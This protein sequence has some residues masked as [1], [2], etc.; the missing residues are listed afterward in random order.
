MGDLARRLWRYVF[1][2]V[3]IKF[4]VFAVLLGYVAAVVYGYEGLWLP[5]WALPVGSLL[6]LAVVVVTDFVAEG[7]W[8]HGFDILNDRSGGLSGFREH[9]EK[10]RRIARWMVRVAFVWGVAATLFL[11]ASGRVMAALAG[12]IAAILAWRYSHVRNECY[13]FVA[14]AMAAA[15]GWFAATNMP[16]PELLPVMLISGMASRLALAFYRYDDYVGIETRAD[17]ESPID[18]LVYYRNLFWI[19]L[20]FPWLAMTMLLFFIMPWWLPF[21]LS[22]LPL[23]EMLI[24][25]RRHWCHISN[26]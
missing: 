9:D 25:R 23:Y 15:G 24:V 12:W 14:V 7:V 10:A 11:I 6:V 13:A 26:H 3:N 16:G 1:P 8:Q 19:I 18:V 5:E 4:S 2:P 20:W 17:F 21:L 22:L